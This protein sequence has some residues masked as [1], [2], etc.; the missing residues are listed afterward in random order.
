MTEHQ[1][2]DRWREFSG[3]IMDLAPNNP[4]IHRIIS[5]YVAGEI[6]TKEE[7][8]CQMVVCLATH[9][10]R[11]RVETILKTQLNVISPSP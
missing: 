1:K 6:I 8:L 7:A 5:S 2:Q 3:P 10:E 4:V 11:Q 9:W